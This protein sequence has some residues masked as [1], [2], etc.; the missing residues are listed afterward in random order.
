MDNSKDQEFWFGGDKSFNDDKKSF[1]QATS[2]GSVSANAAPNDTQTLSKEFSFDQP[3]LKDHLIY[4]D[5][6]LVGAAYLSLFIDLILQ[7]NKGKDFRISRL[8]YANALA[9]RTG[10]KKTVTARIEQNNDRHTLKTTVLDAATNQEQTY[11]DCTVKGAL[12]AEL[13]SDKALNL[14]ELLTR[15]VKREFPEESFYQHPEQKT[16]GPSLQS[17][18][19]VYRLEGG[20]QVLGEIRLTDEIKQ[21]LSEFYLHPALF[22]ACHVTTS[23]VLGNDPVNQHRVPLM[24]KEVEVRYVEN[25]NLD[26]AFCLVELVQSNDQISEM[27]FK[28]ADSSG[29][30]IADITGFTTKT[31]PSREA[32]FANQNASP[33]PAAQPASQ[34]EVLTPQQQALSTPTAQASPQISQEVSGKNLEKEIRDYL[35]KKLA[36][37]LG[38]DYQAVSS[39]KNFMDMGIDSNNILGVVQGIESELQIELYPTLLFEHQNIGALTQYFYDEHKDAF[40]TLLPSEQNEAVSQVVTQTIAQPVIAAEPAHVPVVT[41]TTQNVVQENSGTPTANALKK[42][43]Q[44]YLKQKIAVLLSVSSNEVSLSKNFMDLGIESSNMIGVVQ[45][46][47]KER[48]IELYP[49]LLFEHQNIEQLANYFYSEYPNEFADVVGERVVGEQVA[50]PSA[51]AIPTPQQPVVEPS[52]QAVAPSVSSSTVTATSNTAA[53]QTASSSFS[54]NTSMSTV[55]PSVEKSSNRFSTESNDDIAIIGMSGYLPQSGNLEEFWQNLASSR[56]LITEVPEDH[57]AIDAWYSEDRKQQNKTYSRWGGF[58]KNIDKFDA[59]FFGLSPRQAE[60][61]DPQLRLLLQ[62]V[63]HTLEDASA[64]ASI[65][66]TKTGVYV[67]CCF[68]EYWDEVVRARVPIVDYQADSSVMSSLAATVSYMFDLQGGSIPLDNACASSLTA[69]HLAC[70]SLRTGEN[71]QAL[72]GGVNALLSPLHYVYFSRMQALSPTGRCYSFDKKADGYVPGEGVVSML[73][74]PLSKALRDG[75]NIHAVIKASGIN[76]VGRSNNAVSPRPELQTRL[77]KDTWERFSIDPTQLSYME[78]HG[79]GTTLGDPIE[80]NALKAAFKPYTDQ[81]GF[82]RLGSTKAHAGH[83]EGAAGLTSVIKVVLMMKN[84]QIPKM[85]NFEELNPYIKMSDSPFV[86]N[87]ELLDWQVAPGKTRMAGVSSFGM[88]GNNSHVVLEEYQAPVRQPAFNSGLHFIPV[89]AKNATRLQASVQKLYDFVQQHQ[90][91][92]SIE[93]I[94]LTLQVGRLSMAERVVFFAQNLAEFLQQMQSFLQQHTSPHYVFGTAPLEVELTDHF[95]SEEAFAAQVHSLYQNQQ[96][97]EIANLWLAG[98]PVDWKNLRQGDGSRKISLPGYAFAQDRYWIPDEFRNKDGENIAQAPLS[99]GVITRESAT[100]N[101]LP[102]AQTNTAY[103]LKSALHPL[104][105][106]N[107]SRFDETRFRTVFYGGEFYLDQHR[108]NNAPLL[109]GVAYME[110]AAVATQFASNNKVVGLRNVSWIQPVIV[111]EQEV[112]VAIQLEAKASEVKFKITS[113]QTKLHCQGTVLTSENFLPSRQVSIAEIESRCTGSADPVRIYDEFSRQGIVYGDAFRSLTSIR[114]NTQEVCA[115]YALKPGRAIGIESFLLDPSVMDAA[116]QATIGLKF[117]NMTEQTKKQQELPFAINHVTIHSALPE[118]GV[119]YVRYTAGSG[120][121]D[122]VSNHDIDICDE[123][124]RVCVAIAGFST[125]LIGG[126]DSGSESTK[127]PSSTSVSHEMASVARITAPVTS[128]VNEPQPQNLLRGVEA[129]LQENVADILKLRIEDVPL[130]DEMGAYGLDS[131]TLTEL[132]NRVAENLDIQ[133]TPTVFFEYPTLEAFAQY[134]LDDYAEIIQSKMGGAV[135]P[136]AHSVA[137]DLIETPVAVTDTNQNPGG[138]DT[139]SDSTQQLEVDLTDQVQQLLQNQVGQILKISPTEIA[140]DEQMNSFGLDSITLTELSNFLV[141][142]LDIQ[143]TPTIFYEYTTLEEFADYL[144]TEHFDAIDRVLSP[145]SSTTN[146]ASLVQENS[147]TVVQP[148]IAENIVLD[149]SEKIKTSGGHYSDDDVAIVGIS[150]SFPMADDVDEFWKNLLDGRDC[151]SEIPR[152]RWNWSE[153]YGD[154]FREENKSNVKWGGF[155]RDLDKFDPLFFGI[156]PHEAILMDP[157]QRVLMEHAWAAIEDAGHSPKDYWGTATGVF[158]GIANTGYEKRVMESDIPI[159]GHSSTAVVP[160]AGPNRLSY[161]MNFTGPSE[162]IETACSSALVAIHRGVMSIQR[163]E[164]DYVLAGGVNALLAP[165]VHLSFNKAGMLCEDGRCKTFSENANGYVRG[166]GAGIVFLKRLSEAKKDRNPI[167]AV[168][169]GSAENHGGRA[170]SLTAPNINAQANLLISAYKE[171]NIDPRTVSYIEAHGTGTPLGDPVEINALKKAFG[172][173]YRQQGWDNSVFENSQGQ[174]GLGSVKSNIGHLELAAG[175]AGVT[176][177]LNSMKHG[178][179]PPSIHCEQTNSYIDLDNSPFYIVKESKQWQRQTDASGKIIP[180]RAGVSS[181]GFGGVNA[182]IVLEEHIDEAATS[183]IQL[184]TIPAARIFP[185]SA[186]SEESMLAAV[187]KLDSFLDGFDGRLADLAFTLQVGRMP[188]EHRFVAVASNQSELR[189]CLSE[190]LNNPKSEQV[191]ANVTRE[192][193]QVIIAN[194][195]A[196]AEAS[197]K[198]WV[199]GGSFSWSE[200]YQIA[201]GVRRLS[202]PT[203]AFAR[204]RYWLAEESFALRA[205][206]QGKKRGGISF[207]SITHPLL[208]EN[209]STLY[210]QKYVSRLNSHDWYFSDHKIFGDGILPGVAYVEMARAAVDEATQQHVVSVSNIVW[211]STLVASDQSLPQLN[212]HICPDADSANIEFQIVNAE[213]NLLQSEGVI[214]VGESNCLVEKIDVEA[215]KTSCSGFHGKTVIYDAFK[216]RGI[217]YGTHFQVLEEIYTDNAVVLAK[218]QVSDQAFETQKMLPW[219][220]SVLDGALQSVIGFSLHDSIAQSETNDKHTDNAMFVPFSLDALQLHS[221]AIIQDQAMVDGTF[222]VIAKQLKAFEGKTDD[223]DMMRYRIELVDSNGNPIATFDGFNVR[224]IANANQNIAQKSLQDKVILGGYEWHDDAIEQSTSDLNS[225]AVVFSSD[226]QLIN[227]LERSGLSLDLH[228]LNLSAENTAY[229]APFVEVFDCVK[230]LLSQKSKQIKPLFIVLPSDVPVHHYAALTGLLKTAQM[231]NPKFL[232]RVITLEQFNT[233]NAE[234]VV[235]ILANEASVADPLAWVS[236]SASGERKGLF[237]SDVNYSGNDQ[238]TAVSEIK[239]GGTYWISGGLGGL[240]LIFAKHILNTA[241]TRVVL[242]GRSE[243]D[244]NK[245]LQITALCENANERVKYIPVDFTS[246]DAVT[247]A[248]EAIVGEFGSLNGVIHSAGIIRDAFILQKT[249]QEIDAVWSGKVKGVLSLDNATQG[250][251]L[252]FFM[253]FSSIAGAFGSLGQ[254]DYAGAN[255]FLNSYMTHRNQ[256]VENGQRNGRSMSLV[257]PLWQDGGMHVDAAT[258][259]RMEQASGLTTLQT[260]LGIAAFDYA[261]QSGSEHLVVLPGDKEKIRQALP[262]KALPEAAATSEDDISMSQTSV[263]VS[264]EKPT[265]ETLGTDLDAG[266]LRAKGSSYLKKYLSNA[267]KIPAHKIDQKADLD[268]YGIDS[269]MVLKLSAELEKQ[270]GRLPKT[271]FFEYKSIEELSGYFAEQHTAQ[272]IEL[273]GLTE[274]LSSATESTSTNTRAAAKNTSVSSNSPLSKPSSANVLSSKMLAS[275]SA[276]LRGQSSSRVYGRQDVAIIGIDGRYPQAE[277]LA[278]YWENLKS[279]KDCITEIPEARWNHSRIYDADKSKP[280]SVY[281]RWG[282]FLNDIDKFDP[283]F[284]NISPREAEAMDPQ[285]RLFLQSAWRCMEDAGYTRD[286]LGKNGQRNLGVYVGV[287]YEEYQMYAVQEQ[288]RGNNI[289]L[290]GNP[291]SIANRVSYVLNL[292]GP[293]MAIDTMCSSSITSI[294]LACQN[295]R[296]GNCSAAFAGGVNLSVHPNKYIFLSQ[297]K[298]ISSSG[299]CESFGEGG[300]GYVP[301]EGVGC[302]MLKLLSDAERDGDHI[303]GVIRG[304]ALNHGGKTNGYTVPNPVAQAD[305]IRQALTDAQVDA[306]AISYIEAHGT[307]TSLGDPIEINGL[308]KAFAGVENQSCALGSAKSNIGHCESAAGIAGISKVLLQL[309]HGHIVPSIHS[310]VLNPNIEFDSTPF[311]VQ[312]ELTEWKRPVIS[313]KEQNRIAGISSFGAGGSNAHIIIEEYRAPVENTQ[314]PVVSSDKEELILLSAKTQEALKEYAQDLQQYIAANPELSLAALAYTLQVGRE[315]MDVRLAFTAASITEVGERLSRFIAE[316]NSDVDIFFAQVTDN[317]TV[318]TLSADDEFSELLATWLEK[319]RLEKVADLWVQGLDIDWSDVYLNRIN[320]E[321]ISL[322]TYP[323][324]RERYWVE[325]TSDSTINVGLAAEQLHPLVHSNTSDIYGQKYASRLNLSN[326]FIQDHKI[327]GQYLLPGVAYMEMARFAGENSSLEK[328]YSL[329]NTVWSTPVILDETESTTLETRLSTREEENILDFDIVSSDSEQSHCEGQIVFGH[330]DG[331]MSSKLDIQQISET[332]DRHFDHD[333]IYQQFR[334]QGFEYGASL[335]RLH[336]VKTNGQV[337]LSSATI[338]RSQEVSG[339]AYGLHPGLM[340]A[341]LQSLIGFSLYQSTSGQEQKAKGSLVPFA[342]DRVD[343][344]GQLP[345]KVVIYVRDADSENQW[346]SGIK[347]YDIDIL[348]ESGNPCLAIS[349]FKVREI[350]HA[351]KI[352]TFTSKTLFGSYEWQIDN[353]N[354]PDNFG[355]QELTIHNAENEVYQFWTSSQTLVDSLNGLVNGEHNHVHLLPAAKSDSESDLRGQFNHVFNE[356]KRLI[357][358]KP[359]ARKNIAICVEDNFCAYQLAHI[360]GLLKSARLEHNKINARLILVDG[361]HYSDANVVQQILL[362]ELSLASHTPEVRYDASGNR[363]IKT[364]QYTPENNAMNLEASPFAENGVYWI[365]GGLGGLGVIFAKRMLELKATR[366][367]L[368]GRSQLAGHALETFESLSKEYGADRVAYFAVDVSR[369]EEVIKTHKRILDTYKKLNGVIHSAGAIRDAF[370]VQKTEQEIESVWQGKV[371]GVINLDLATANDSLDFFVTFSSMA[372][373]IGNVGQADYAAANSLLDSFAKLRQQRVN[374]GERKGQSLS[375]AWPLWREGGMQV[376][377]ATFALLEKS[378]GVSPLEVEEGLDAFDFCL[379]SGLPQVAVIPGDQKRIEQSI[380]GL[381]EK[382]LDEK[383]IDNKQDP[384]TSAESRNATGSAEETNTNELQYQ[385]E[386]YIKGLLSKTLKLPS[387][388]IDAGQPLEKYGIDSVMVMALTSDLESHFGELSKTLFFEYQTISELANYFVEEHKDALISALGLNTAVKETTTPTKQTEVVNEKVSAS[389][390]RSFRRQARFGAQET[391]G[392][393]NVRRGKTGALDIAIVGVSGRYPQANNIAEYWENLKQG[394]D[395]ISSIP[396]GRWDTAAYTAENGNSLISSWGGFVPNVD[397][398]DPL[399]FNISPREAEVID[400]QER[401]FLQ[402]AWECMEDAGYTRASIAAH[403]NNRDVGVFVGVMYEEYQLYGAQ[404]QL[405]GNPVGLTANPSGIAN[406]VSYFC[407]FHGPSMAVDTMCSSS[408]T[409]IHLACQSLRDNQCRVALAGGVNLSLHPNKYL[410]LNQGNFISSKGRCESFGEGGDG[411][412]PGEGVGCLLLKPLADAERDGDHIYGV[413]KGTAVNHGGKTNGYT[414]PNP[415]AQAKVISKAVERANISPKAISYIEAHGTGTSLGDP[416][417]I[418]GLNRVF[419]NAGV[420]PQTCAIGSAKSNIGHCESAAGVAGVTKVLLQMQHGQ[421]VPS[422]HSSTLNPNIDFTKSPF[423]V[424]QEL[425]EWQRKTINGIEQPRIAGVSSFGAGGSNAHVIIEEYRHTQQSR[426]ITLDEGGQLVVLSARTKAQLETYASRYLEFLQN[427]NAIPSLADI[428]FTSQTGRETHKY[429][430]A[431]HCHSIENLITQLEQIVDGNAKDVEGIYIGEVSQ[432]VHPLALLTK[433]DDL[434]SSVMRWVEKG[435]LAEIAEQ[436]VTGFEFDWS[437]LYSANIKPKRVALPTYPFLQNRYWFEAGSSDIVVGQTAMQWSEWQPGTLESESGLLNAFKTHIDGKLVLVT[438][439]ITSQTEFQYFSAQINSVLATTDSSPAIPFSSFIIGQEEGS[440]AQL[441]NQLDL[442]AKT[443][444][445]SLAPTGERYQKRIASAIH[446]VRQQLPEAKVLCLVDTSAELGSVQFDNLIR[447]QSSDKKWDEKVRLIG[448]DNFAHSVRQIKILFNEYAH[449]YNQNAIQTSLYVGQNRWV[450]AYGRPV[451]TS[452]QGE[453]D[454][455]Q[456]SSGNNIYLI[457]KKWRASDIAEKSEASINGNALIVCTP[458]TNKIA[459]AYIAK[460]THIDSIKIVLGGNVNSNTEQSFNVDASEPEMVGE[461]VEDILSRFKSIATVVDLSALSEAGSDKEHLSLF[462]LYQKLV[463]QFTDIHIVYLT[464]CLQVFDNAQPSL[465]GVK[466]AGLIKMLSAEYPHVQARTIDVDGSIE[467]EALLRTIDSELSAT[468]EQTEIT[469]RHGQRYVPYLERVSVDKNKVSPISFDKNGVYVISGGTS[470]I[471]LQMAHHLVSK[472]VTKLV[473]MGVTRLPEQDQWDAQ[474]G[475]SQVSESVKN[476]IASLVQLREQG[477]T[478]KIYTGSLAEEEKLKI[479]FSDVASSFGRVRG[480]IHSAAA[481]AASKESDFAFVRKSISTLE[482]VFEPKITGT[483]IL[484]RVVKSDDLDFFVTFSSTAGQIPNFMRGMSDYG[485]ANAF[486]D[487][488][489]NYHN[490]TS[491]TRYRSIAW[492]G[493]SDVGN[494]TTDINMQKMSEDGAKKYGLL[495]NNAKQGVELFDYALNTET[496]QA[497][498]LPSL[499]NIDVFDSRVDEMLLCE[500]QQPAKKD[501]PSKNQNA[502]WPEFEALLERL[503]V[504]ELGPEILTEIDLDSLEDWQVE[505][506]SALLIEEEAEAE[507]QAQPVSP[508]KTN[509]QKSSSSIEKS[510]TENTVAA[511]A[512]AVSETEEKPSIES[513]KMQLADVLAEVLKLN[514]EEIDFSE[515]LQSYGLDSISGTQI[516]SKLEQKLSFEMSTA[517]LIEYATINDLA[518]KIIEV[519]TASEETL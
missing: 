158:V 28:L 182:H 365:T 143:L 100:D 490:L 91:A 60:W 337:V 303:Y 277:N 34:A 62:S 173:L 57:W 61:I 207:S 369:K 273:L 7:N 215:I 513:I 128:S 267:L 462:K 392:S 195:I 298:F 189:A 71:E 42:A 184:D 45:E 442:D 364:W 458:D 224:R 344:F 233:V 302:V 472:G 78:A 441:K 316:P 152:D 202:L 4:G 401:L 425:G 139:Y 474:L 216:T 473:L 125:R 343:I 285:E 375:L 121:H 504:D 403:E 319:G 428:A 260:E 471:G 455:A 413:I 108:V 14:K 275:K 31:V 17:V 73:I 288:Q 433:D 381:G 390:T 360:S 459:D 376:D 366:V 503:K 205:S 335:S 76:H 312:Q 396:E 391:S 457:E 389:T 272:F 439:S 203:Y 156:S 238:R 220:L 383:P 431:I 351:Q 283:L 217:E 370:I 18:F 502:S 68:Q 367:I 15:A 245:Q 159:E 511:T 147:L 198:Q 41:E 244:S 137:D 322:P 40:D 199:N 176:K 96:L 408:L 452:I 132:S 393:N 168:I 444:F 468:L 145:E 232:G 112:D 166:E 266:A 445:I 154:P 72:V 248:Y 47:E 79:T 427:G 63:Q 487:A 214:Q 9:I 148:E 461:V 411:Y 200:E 419:L 475:S 123:S 1:G 356:I 101:S 58:L 338:D 254:A 24:M 279:G 470:G 13:N 262:L 505:K 110:M 386:N 446:S 242:S 486:V 368:S 194:N 193:G 118:R 231:E 64:A 466:T 451:V 464:R 65:F 314:P 253:C 25:L 448:L 92:L 305:V 371:N 301:G 23:Y 296:E 162:P 255:S 402:H 467:D 345:N 355:N 179:L 477:V 3:L 519:L 423:K 291:S 404:E 104:V 435:R 265:S 88:T 263:A 424:Q 30:V 460:N 406:R 270:F 250:E 8:N 227:T 449:C 280:G 66:G 443:V 169:K 81:T 6:V 256:L 95:P 438:D 105:Q 133:L 107:C 405:K 77:L 483:E 225:G 102:Q 479:F 363:W 56:D 109:P 492:V 97:Q 32:I 354:H 150:G 409:S 304:S 271:L 372:G 259:K 420:E 491:K 129:F 120:F 219:P 83:L 84:R 416:I 331:T 378:I 336:Y 287:M 187:R 2:A 89:S 440:V 140:L 325:L 5:P 94:S 20:K 447:Y 153:I 394:R 46:I 334:T 268:K 352:T 269:V 116:L 138:L 236:Y 85:P 346:R 209:S 206:G 247:S 12:S 51:V 251:N 177:V 478:L 249:H 385:A 482:K 432:D 87:T 421:I 387:H 136:A 141:E 412:V 286:T 463:A 456:A 192:K 196:D 434:K 289:G 501:M 274:A 512:T 181:F 211:P 171:A 183:N 310:A 374:N 11:A 329:K 49:T 22:D 328:V 300:D 377:D 234:D 426:D 294:H 318:S 306:Q 282:G 114:F 361:S 223:K 19:S 514:R 384:N 164:S 400:P 397:K 295:L 418:T 379:R 465:N 284:F 228:V 488:F 149:T 493:W 243:L 348:D 127:K 252:D 115:R 191:I 239:E 119:M 39:A 90:T 230:Q 485:T 484:H 146:S 38:V 10:E 339:G 380:L 342:V 327:N 210:E 48:S 144:V 357:T 307:G 33:A 186:K 330:N 358:A 321:K 500:A 175:I 26:Y 221:P 174:C 395:C 476:K 86:I 222:Y 55:Q 410:L 69:L 82:C 74:K 122:T 213:N 21:S 36:P 399:F 299:R 497:A 59:H 261:L 373:V 317:T 324:A 453:A 218:L 290:G 29:F 113:D 481:M 27:N 276:V 388:R 52:T 111:N 454:D 398:F 67:G 37:L 126:D 349:G 313:G 429:R 135:L 326:P 516:A 257:W 201:C 510:D 106:E 407:D 499:V 437:L 188:M 165:E 341:A 163:G 309:K 124:G 170:Q 35:R 498:V 430:M 75:D 53:T 506:L 180:R 350:K 98:L 469:Y 50:G 185:V 54:V 382:E 507:Y 495:F 178:V 208:S 80:V 278:E 340:D 237:W 246:S 414:V 320:P 422:I 167:Y 172:E 240:G 517:W 131:I 142:T 229:Q 508:V 353:A 16:Y 496:D 130:D 190:F 117:A 155:L 494:H 480:V 197:A 235:K 489:A 70:Q 311:Y 212:I 518:R 160:S 99:N 332:L 308:S 509:F 241:D 258:L 292:N 161:F 293:S 417:E 362:R 450:K 333:E 415:V 315:A 281:S 297:G 347:Q 93:D 44:L 436:W 204:E 151:I 359:S 157:Q 515:S 103:T 226:A 264:E 43:I 134:L 323:F